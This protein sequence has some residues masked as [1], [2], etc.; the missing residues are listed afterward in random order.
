MAQC[1]SLDQAVPMNRGHPVG[2]F[3]KYCVYCVV[4]YCLLLSNA[5]VL[6]RG[7]SAYDA[8]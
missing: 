7:V 3:G 6:T 4:Y 5:L 8:S 1:G 2:K